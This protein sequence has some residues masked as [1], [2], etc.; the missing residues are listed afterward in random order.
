M[1]A[2]LI[3]FSSMALASSALSATTES[4]LR[5]HD[6]DKIQCEI[7][8]QSESW[9]GSQ[10]LVEQ[11]KPISVM[12]VGSDS[13]VHE[14]EDE[15]RFDVSYIQRYGS[16]TKSLEIRA[17]VHDGIQVLDENLKPTKPVEKLFDGKME[18]IKGQWILLTIPYQTKS[19]QV[20]CISR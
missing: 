16:K 8:S 6:D 5:L 1:K 9:K 2:F 14:F 4:G 10:R 15:T 20:R 7:K 13:L 18:V 12:L 11:V 3:L 19:Y 17:N